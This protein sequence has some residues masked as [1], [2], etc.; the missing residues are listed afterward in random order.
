[1]PQALLP[2]LLLVV[3][4]TTSGCGD[5]AAKPSAEREREDCTALSD[6][7]ARE[8]YAREFTARVAEAD[9]PLAEVEAITRE[10]RAEG[11]FLLSNCHGIMHTVG[12]SHARTQD[13]TLGSLMNHLPQSNDPGCPAGF[14]HGV[15]TA[16][17]P[18][19]DLSD[20][21]ASAAVCSQAETRYQRYSCVHGFGHA[22]M[23]AHGDELEP[24]LELCRALGSEAP[25]CAQGA[26][27]DYWFAVA[28][29]DDTERPAEAETDPALLCADQPAEF[30]R[31]CWYRAFV[32]RRPEGAVIETPNDI[33][34]LCTALRGVQR[35]ACLTAASVIGP[36]DPRAQIPLCT[37]FRGREA[38]ACVRGVK[39][40][41]LL[42][43][44]R[45]ILLETIELCEL[46]GAPATRAACY[47]WLGKTLAVVT[48]GAFVA[49]GCPKLRGA[50]ARAACAAGA[51]SVD[52]PLVTFS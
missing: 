40:Q 8:C 16:I 25:D 1:V 28:G 29:L 19:L 30:V 2:A 34:R 48:D 50:A 42:G 45:E 41:N 43:Q 36:A 11:G 49:G 5:G 24:A 26:F 44:P 31:P 21:R 33:D 51:R 3:L 14:A 39:A 27:H 7:A 23:R 18:Q 35:E 20:P 37:G 47:R 46:F 32:D 13:V 12:R 38:V 52:E 6:D 22:F 10:S 9:D 15:V 17:A 4:A